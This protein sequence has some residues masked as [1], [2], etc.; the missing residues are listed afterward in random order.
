MSDET[1]PAPAPPAQQALS[2]KVAS[3]LLVI[4][5]GLTGGGVGSTVTIVSAPDLEIAKRDAVDTALERMRAEVDREIAPM[6][7]RLERIEEKL[8]RLIERAD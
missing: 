2:P 3:A 7:G 5:A 1:N 6:R 8:D 4:M